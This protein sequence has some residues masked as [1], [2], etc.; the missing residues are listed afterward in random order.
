[1]SPPR[2]FYASGPVVFV[3]VYYGGV[4]DQIAIR[5]MKL[6]PQPPPSEAIRLL[7]RGSEPLPPNHVVD[8]LVQLAPVLNDLFA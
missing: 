1:M 4:I 5:M 6:D 3:G 7:S 2:E 8:F